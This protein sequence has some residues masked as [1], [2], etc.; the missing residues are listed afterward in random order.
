VRPAALAAGVAAN[1]VF[2]WNATARTIVAVEA[3]LCLST[4]FVPPP[5]PPPPGTCATDID[6]T[7]NGVCAA[8]RCACDAPW[9]AALDCSVL[10]FAP[11]PLVR[12]FPP[13]AHNETTWGGSIAAGADGRYHM[14]VAEMVNECPLSTWGQNSQCRHAVADVPEGPYAAADV[15]VGVW[16]ERRLRGGSAR[17]RAR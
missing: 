9:T 15:A 5:P 7:L 10:A 3:G 2:R 16:C 14:F 12:G 1:D 4:A 13:P 8:G 6:C 11:S 17:G